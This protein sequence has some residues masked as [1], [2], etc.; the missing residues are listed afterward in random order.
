MKAG[1][2]PVS[3]AFSTRREDNLREVAI[4]S[5]EEKSEAVKSEVLL[6]IYDELAVDLRELKAMA[7]LIGEYKGDF[8]QDALLSGIEGVFQ[9][10][11]DSIQEKHEAIGELYKVPQHEGVV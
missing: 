8:D 7:W 3:L 2:L 1:S 9:G 4:M 5:S 10:I 6:N 11:H